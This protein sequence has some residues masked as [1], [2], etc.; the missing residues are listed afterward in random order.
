[1]TQRGTLASGIPPLS[2]THSSA[3]VGSWRQVSQINVDLE[4]L[5]L[6][7]G[8]LHISFPDGRSPPAREHKQSLSNHAALIKGWLTLPKGLHLAEISVGCSGLIEKFICLCFPCLDHGGSM[9][10]ETVTVGDKRLA[11]D[12]VVKAAESILQRL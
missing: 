3:S 5:R 8:E 12:Y 4:D 11:R 7:A 9:R 2:L 10:I 1:M 6:S